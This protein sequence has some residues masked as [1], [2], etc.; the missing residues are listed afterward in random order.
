MKNTVNLALFASGSGTN[1]ENIIHYF[2]DYSTINVCCILCNNSN[3]GVIERANRLGV[4][5]L[6]FNRANFYDSDIVIDYLRHKNVDLIVLAGFLW[7][8]P[9]KI[10]V[11]YNNKIIN[12]HPALLPKYG[13]KGM[14]GNAVHK[15]VFENK[16]EYTGITIHYVNKD[17]D[18]GDIIFQESIKIDAEDSPDSIADKVHKLEY[19]YYPTIIKKIAVNLQHNN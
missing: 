16:D 12:I 6:V 19:T 2:N 10:I 4:D 8:I 17:Y 14:Y 13:G 5:I 3:A 11:S 7:L 9:E 18:K 15:A 1:V